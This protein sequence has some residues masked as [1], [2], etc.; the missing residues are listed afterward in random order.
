SPPTWWPT[1]RS[2]RLAYRK[3]TAA[4]RATWCSTSQERYRPPPTKG[5]TTIVPTV[6]LARSL[7]AAHFRETVTFL[8]DGKR[9][10]AE[11]I[12]AKRKF[13]AATELSL[14]ERE[15]QEMKLARC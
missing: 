8:F 1:H 9:W 5:V 7:R 11:R 15:A 4:S 10:W 3:P 2:R 13:T 6:P 14:S 12:A